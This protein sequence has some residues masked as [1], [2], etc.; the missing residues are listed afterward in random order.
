MKLAKVIGTVVATRK[1]PTLNGI[2]ILMIQPLDDDMKVD[3]DPIAA[4]DAETQAGPGDLVWWVLSRE[5][6]YV[7]PDW[8]SPVDAAVAGIVDEVHQE[9]VGI[10]D[11]EKIFI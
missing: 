6:C 3:G 10:K 1:D 4:V 8:F 5:S 7:L 2:K 11:R 9:D